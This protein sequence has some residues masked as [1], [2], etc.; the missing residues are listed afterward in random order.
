MTVSAE[1][2]RKMARQYLRPEEMVTLVVGNWPQRPR[3]VRTLPSR[4]P[5]SLEPVN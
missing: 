3:S 5:L 1:D 2:V 4:D